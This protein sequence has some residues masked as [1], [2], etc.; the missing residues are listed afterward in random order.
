VRLALALA[1][2]LA[3]GCAAIPWPHAAWTPAA[4]RDAE[5]WLDLRGAVHVHTAASH[6]SPGTLEALVAA[7]RAAGTRW[8]ALTEHTRPGRLGPHGEIE[9]V[10]VIPGFET[11]AA[12][13]SLL[14]IGVRDLPPKTPDAAALVRFAHAAGGVAYVGH[15]ERS[16]LAEPEAYRR[17]APDGIEIANLHANAE[18]RTLSLGWR[19]TL[20]PST[21]ALRTLLFV[22]PANLAAWDSLPGPPPIVAAVDA[23][24]KIR[25]LGPLGGT[26]DRYRDVLR[27]L[28][29]HVLARDTSEAAI[30]E[31]LR[32]GRSYVA[33]EGLA[34]V[35]AF[36]F[37]PVARG[38][39]LTAPRPATLS[40][41]C[42]GRRVATAE[43]T[44]A[45]LAHPRDARWCRAEAHLDGRL[46]V[47]TSPRAMPM[48]PP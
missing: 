43:G 39:R 14:A 24:A 2:G 26:A 22:P 42:D 10:T 9:G 6:D 28:T 31:A 46:W 1:A 4:D 13:G 35:D 41:V 18:Q 30:L 44:R 16:A 21:W 45:V 37:E 8:I 5:G 33:L 36:R 25:L 27:A 47:F 12:G 3:T 19:M 34:R 40:L 29:T 48:T 23:H 7:A 38:F 32:A 15:L 11:R 20:L 17:A